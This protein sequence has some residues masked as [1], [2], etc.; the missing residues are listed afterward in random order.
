MFHLKV[1]QKIVDAAEV[2][3]AAPVLDDNGIAVGGDEDDAVR[4]RALAK[5]FMDIYFSLHWQIRMSVWAVISPRWSSPP[6][7]SLKLKEVTLLKL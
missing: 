4:I 6:W 7:R 3:D 2:V 5:F 1:E